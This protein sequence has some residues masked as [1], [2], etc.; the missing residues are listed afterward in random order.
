[1]CWCSARMQGSLWGSFMRPKPG[2]CFVRLVLFPTQLIPIDWTWL[3]IS[4][5]ELCMSCLN[6]WMNFLVWQWYKMLNTSRGIIILMLIYHSLPPFIH[7]SYL[8]HSLPAAGVQGEAL[9]EEICVVPDWLVRRQLV[10]DQRSSY[11]LYSGEHDWGRWG[12]RNH[13]DRY[14][15]SWNCPWRLQLG[16]NTQNTVLSSPLLL[17][18]FVKCFINKFQLLKTTVE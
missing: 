10:Q 5:I 7:L 2:R 12:T 4:R 11:Q 6:V 14:A 1:M 8:V 15:E 16:K 13:W 9:R 3:A 17:S 18:C